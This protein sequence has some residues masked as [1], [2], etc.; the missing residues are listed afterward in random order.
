[1]YAYKKNLICFFNRSFR[2]FSTINIPQYDYP[3]NPISHKSFKSTT[4]GQTNRS[5]RGLW[6]GKQHT[7]G[8]RKTFSMK[9]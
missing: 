3:F 6:Q 2:S 4:S 9:Q 5:Q 8:Y 1:M 7:K